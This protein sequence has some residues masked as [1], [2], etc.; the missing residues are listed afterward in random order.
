MILGVEMHGSPLILS[1]Y[2][3]M[4]G[5]TITGS[6]FGGLKPKYDVPMLAKKYLDKVGAIYIISK[7]ASVLFLTPKC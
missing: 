7:Y 6:L 1:P 2:D 5:K 4:S 3:I